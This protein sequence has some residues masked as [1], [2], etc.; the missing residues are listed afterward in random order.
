MPTNLAPA[1]ATRDH[2][3]PPLV[4]SSH[5]LRPAARDAVAALIAPLGRH[6]SR[7]WKEVGRDRLPAW[8]AKVVECA[9]EALGAAR[10]QGPDVFTQT[11]HRVRAC[12]ATHEALAF[13]GFDAGPR[14]RLE[15]SLVEM[16]HAET[17]CISAAAEASH[18]LTE[19]NLQAVRFAAMET[20]RRAEEVLALTTEQLT[21]VHVAVAR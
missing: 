18:A 5:R 6:P 4:A 13:A 7:L 14:G 10:H 9:R 11:A 20:I 2:F 16:I 8:P 21:R 17:D 19:G 12:F 1:P 3:R 15:S